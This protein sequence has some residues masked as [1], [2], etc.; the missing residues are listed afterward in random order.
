MIICR[1]ELSQRRPGDARAHLSY[2]VPATLF[3]GRPVPWV[4]IKHLPNIMRFVITTSL[5]AQWGKGIEIFKNVIINPLLSEITDIT[6]PTNV[7]KHRYLDL[8]FSKYS[9]INANFPTTTILIFMEISKSRSTLPNCK[10]N[11]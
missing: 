11:R 8:L 3:I 2:L 1:T 9:Y 6:V 10:D 7:A 5:F 4:N